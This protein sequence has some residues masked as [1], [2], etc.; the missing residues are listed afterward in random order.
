MYVEGATCMIVKSSTKQYPTIWK[1]SLEIL[2]LK[3]APWP[4]SLIRFRRG[5]LTMAHIAGADPFPW[6]KPC[7]GGMSG[8]AH[9]S[10]L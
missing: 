8:I 9:T 7:E 6:P 4:D 1:E 3:T 10:P 5:D 2:H